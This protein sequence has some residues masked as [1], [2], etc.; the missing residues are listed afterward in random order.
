A[1]NPFHL[2]DAQ[3]ADRPAAGRLD[4][5]GQLRDPAPLAA[6]PGVALVCRGLSR[7]RA[8]GDHQG[9]WRAR[10]ADAGAL[11]AGA[12]ARHGQPAV[13]SRRLA[14]DPRARCLPPAGAGLAA[15]DA[16]GCPGRW[17]PA[18][19]RLR[20]RDPVRA[21]RAALCRAQR[22]PAFAA[23]FPRHHRGGLVA[24]VAVAA[25]GTPGLV[26]ATAPGRRAPLAAAGLGRPVAGVLLAQP[27]QA[28]CVYPAGPADAGPGA[29]A[30][31]AR[32]AA[33]DRGKACGLRPER[34]AQRRPHLG[35]GAGPDAQ[36]A[37]G[38]AHRRD[39]R[40]THL[41][42]V[43]GNR[44]AWPGDRGRDQGSS[45][46]DGLAVVCRCALV[47]VWAVGLSAVEWRTLGGCGD[48]RGAGTRRAA[49]SNR[50]GGLEGAE[51][52]DAGGP[53]GGIRVPAAVARAICAG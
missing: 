47:A 33:S 6:W 26:A 14:L 50:P 51:P 35:G 24:V 31:P 11:C 2:P 27:G 42:A 9:R 22:P 7:G 48:G 46:S 41:V 37:L 30:A 39:A 28:R 44:S 21:D 3:C 25:L 19:R 34:V 40:S 5:P 49:G 43:P 29:D 20:A 32:F 38:R 1:D 16:A 12:L 17:R 18:T 52:A 53:E 8:W 15:A 36:P 45:C 4:D 23:V 10:A 13:V